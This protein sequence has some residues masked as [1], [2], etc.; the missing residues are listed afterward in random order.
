MRSQECGCTAGFVSIS[1]N[2][3]SPNATA[4]KHVSV[5]SLAPCLDCAEVPFFVLP[6]FVLY[7]CQEHN[8]PPRSAACRWL[9][10]SGAL[11]TAMHARC[12]GH[13]AGSD[14]ERLAALALCYVKTAAHSRCC[15]VLSFANARRVSA[16][17]PTTGEN[18]DPSPLNSVLG[19][20][21]QPTLCGALL[22]V[23]VALRLA[24]CIA[25][26]AWQTAIPGAWSQ[27]WASR[28]T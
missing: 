10:S 5:G 25:L 11:P 15:C 13:Q 19:A 22:R 17:Q 1:L 23:Q 14:T 18:V 21:D 12:C 6:F 26:K 7:Y 8:S 24:R 28:V 20:R 9:L 27:T 3:T 16:I 2:C 4:P